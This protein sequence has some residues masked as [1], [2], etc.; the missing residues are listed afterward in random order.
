MTRKDLTEPNAKL[1]L[2]R[3]AN[4][5]LA[6]GST[7]ALLDAQSLPFIPYGVLLILERLQCCCYS[8]LSNLTR[9]FPVPAQPR[10]VPPPLAADR[11]CAGKV[12]MHR[13]SC[14]LP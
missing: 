5:G 12:H 9:A 3:K 14:V 8:L 10:P 7:D 11:I 13:S 4:L 6:A 2:G 1:V